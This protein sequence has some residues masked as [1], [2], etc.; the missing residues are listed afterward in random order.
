MNKMC[1]CVLAQ[2]M[3]IE[4]RCYRLVQGERNRMVLMPVVL[5]N[6]K[7]QFYE[8]SPLPHLHQNKNSS[9]MRKCI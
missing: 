9:A 1:E 6:I 8:P 4:S 7:T 5:A 3:K 2:F